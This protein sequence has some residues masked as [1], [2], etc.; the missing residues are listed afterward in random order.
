ML[1]TLSRTVVCQDPQRSSTSS[2]SPSCFTP[3][4][5]KIRA[6]ETCLATAKKTL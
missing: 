2:A 5:V 6:R 1:K 3:Q 4:R